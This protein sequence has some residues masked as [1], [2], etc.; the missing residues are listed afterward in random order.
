[1]FAGAKSRWTTSPTTEGRTIRVRCVV[2]PER[3]QAMLIEHLGLDL[4]RRLSISAP[5]QVVPV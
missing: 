1:V 4:P 2:K 5:L 3:A